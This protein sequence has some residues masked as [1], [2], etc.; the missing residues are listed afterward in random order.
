MLLIIS[1]IATALA[2]ARISRLIAIDQI[3][4]PIRQWVLKR[5]GDN[6]WFTFLIHCP[7]CASV[8]VGAA[9]SPLWWFF[10]DKAWFLI[11]A[12]ALA[13]AQVTSLTTKIEQGD[14]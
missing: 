14:R 12:I 4:L 10:G 9:A 8:W 6:G 5:S 1:L 7:Y 13:F 3:T 11:P 2:V